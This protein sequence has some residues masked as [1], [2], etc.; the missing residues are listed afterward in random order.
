MI[1]DFWYSS[2]AAGGGGGGNDPGDQIGESLRFRGSTAYLENTTIQCPLEY[3][4]SA[5]VKIK[6]NITSGFE[7]SPESAK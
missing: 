3:T 4:F 2:G 5:W 6:G 7:A 1:Q